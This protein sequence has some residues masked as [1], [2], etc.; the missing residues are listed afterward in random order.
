MKRILR[1][2]NKSY[3][4]L[5]FHLMVMLPLKYPN[6]K[7]KMNRL[8]FIVSLVIEVR[9]DVWKKDFPERFQNWLHM[10]NN[11]QYPFYLE[12]ELFLNNKWSDNIIKFNCHFKVNNLN[13]VNICYLSD[14][15]LV[16]LISWLDPFFIN[17]ITGNTK[18]L[19]QHKKMKR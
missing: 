16:I 17:Q 1:D 6:E 3:W 4:F 12:I 13:F 7:L 2:E 15:L 11:N 5:W 10:R 14:V 19:H 9:M 8:S 18:V